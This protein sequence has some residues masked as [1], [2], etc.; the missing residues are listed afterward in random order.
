MFCPKCGAENP[1]NVQLCQSCSWVLSSLSTTQTS[2]DAKTS[3]LAITALVLMIM[4]FFTATLTAIPAIIFGIVALVKINKSNGKLKGKGMAIAGF[5]VPV[6]V[7][8]IM[9]AI[10][11][12]A[13]GKSRQLAHRLMCGTNL[14]GIGK[15]MLIYASDY[16]EKYP[17]SSQWCDLLVECADVSEKQFV[18]QSADDGRSHYAMNKNIEQFG[19]S[20]PSDMVLVFESAPGWNQSGG[21]ELL[22]TDNH[23]GEGCSILFADGHVKFVR[24]QD[25]ND[26]RWTPEYK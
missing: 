6:I 26:L 18:C 11:M 25:I 9:L 22:T 16:D 19:S 1:E 14:S 2:P 15:A 13:L 20:T 8:P 3:G 7:L 12:P 17:T 24:T 10:L 4:I 23:C 5:A 21:R